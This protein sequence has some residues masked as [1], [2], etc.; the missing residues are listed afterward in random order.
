MKINITSVKFD[1]A[2]YPRG[3]PSTTIVEEYADALLAGNIFPPII[4]ESGTNRLLDGYH[5]WKAHKRLVEQPELNGQGE[6]F[7]EIDADFHIIPEG[8]PPKLYAASLSSKHGH[9]LTSG[10]TKDL[11]REICEANPDF[12]AQVIAEYVGRSE[13]TVSDYV[14]DIKGRRK[15]QQRAVI[16][17]LDRL[18]WTQEE[19]AQVVGVT[20]GR[21]AQILLEMPELAKLI[22][23]VLA[24]GIPHLEVAERFNLPLQVVWAI[25]L[26][27][28]DD[29]DRLDRLGIKV[30]PYDVWQFAKCHD[31]F[32][33]QHP[34]RIPGEL[35]AHVLY[36]F[37]QVGDMV[38]DPMAGSGT[39]PDVCLAMGR[40]CYAYDIDDRHGRNDIITHNVALNGW[41]ERIKKADLI[42]WD[43][44]YYKK[45]DSLNIGE[46]GYIDGSISKLSRD[47]YLSF[48]EAR[49]IEAKAQV[50]KGCR[51]AFL[52]SD[53]DG[54]HWEGKP[55]EGDGIF[56]WDYADIIRRA[57]WRIV[58]HVQVPLSTQQVHPDIVNKFRK[59]RRLARLERYL[60]ICES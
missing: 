18:G 46:T 55:G 48:F 16:M 54:E 7:S 3:K 50:K 49:L 6:Q 31:L 20:Q 57:G 13:R 17:R 1:G 23:S 34:G 2:I 21:I 11:A 45:M 52:M 33:S 27:G 12:A 19:V 37:T 39:T 35:V 56:V 43:P 36:F 29:A 41:H 26:D 24:S 15:E 58:R 22:K 5:R 60:L 44:P 47:A 32:G 9:R 30:Q 40:K 53:W 38:I 51:L 4:L 42:F 25:D 10:E 59:S 8:I 28:R 14:K